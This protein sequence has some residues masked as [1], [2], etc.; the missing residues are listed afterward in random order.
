MTAPHHD[1]ASL[2][3]AVSA[4]EARVTDL[5]AARERQVDT[6]AVT[7]EALSSA[8]ADAEQAR[9]RRQLAG[10]HAMLVVD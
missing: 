7:L 10:L 9:G 1:I 3:A 6:L 2:D 5:I 8:R 4:A